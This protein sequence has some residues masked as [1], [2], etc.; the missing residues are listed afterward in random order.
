MKWG[1][2][3][4]SE[5]AIIG[6]GPAGLSAAIQLVRYGLEPLVFEKTSPGGLLRNAN[7]IENYPGFPDGICGPD[8][9]TRITAQAERIGVRLIFEEVLEVSYSE[10]FT[11]RTSGDTYT[12]GILVIAAGTVPRR[13]R[14]PALPAEVQDRLFYEVYPLLGLRDQRIVIIG[15]GDAAFD[16]ALN[17]A[18][19]NT[20]HIL[21]RSRERKC[22]PLLWERASDQAAI[23]YHENTA[24]WDVGPGP[25]KDIILSCRSP[26]GDFTLRA[27]YLIAALGRDPGTDFLSG[28]LKAD[29]ASLE[30][31]GRLYWIGDVKNG[32]YR[33]TAI[34]AGEGVLAA[35]KIYQY[36]QETKR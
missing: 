17:L 32:I 4:K 3:M 2:R 21:N 27:T 23:H 20:V 31:Q 34:A 5:V 25:A 8:L 6:A 35:M 13:L 16:Y 18:R 15:A 10:D 14:E 9:V 26:S 22:L 24:V 29:S 12:T 28:E 33:Q 1:R 11:I 7:W 36:L 19:S 30:S